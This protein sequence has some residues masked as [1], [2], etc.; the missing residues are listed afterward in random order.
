S[1]GARHA[2]E[3]F[4]LVNRVE[5]LASGLYR[6]LASEHALILADNSDN[7]A[8]VLVHACYKQVMVSRAAVSFFWAAVVDRMFWRYDERGYRYL[9][10][11]AGHVCQNLY[12]AGESLG[13]GTCAIA[14]FDDDLLNDA[15][16]LDGKEMFAVYAAALGKKSSS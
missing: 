2:F 6:Y 4:V 13:C 15:L 8:E 10:L 5:G 9:H 1:A 11:D 14:A 3:T 16:E 7:I 12:L